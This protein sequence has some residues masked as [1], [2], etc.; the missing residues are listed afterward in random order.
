MSRDAGE[1]A[2]RLPAYTTYAKPQMTTNVPAA[3]L[4]IKITIRRALVESTRAITIANKA[5]NATTTSDIS[6]CPEQV[7]A[8]SG[9]SGFTREHGFVWIALRSSFNG[10]PCRSRGKR[11][12]DSKKRSPPPTYLACQT[13]LFLERVPSNVNSRL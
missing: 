13:I 3:R 10:A 8:R 2:P 1:M 7:A 5:I 12:T 11:L 6:A 9:P 4:D